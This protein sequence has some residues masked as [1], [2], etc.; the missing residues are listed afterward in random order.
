[1]K[2]P[3][4]A[5]ALL[6]AVLA[7]GRLHAQQMN[8]ARVVPRGWIE[9]R[10]FGDFA[11]YDARFADGGTV[12]LGAPYVPAY[13]SLA[14]R[15]A[16]PVLPSL[17]T[18]VA[19]FFQQTAG[20][21]TNPTAPTDLAIGDVNF[22][23][24]TDLR[25]V[26][27]GVDFGLTSRISLGVT[28]PF[29]RRSSSPTELL[30]RG[31]TVGINA[32]PERNAVLLG[33]IDP[34]YAALGRLAF[35]PTAESAAGAEL[36][37]RVKAIV[38]DSV[39][40]VL[41]TRGV[42]LQELLND[43]GR[44]ALLDADEQAALE[45]RNASAGF[46]L[47]DV[48]VGARVMLFNTAPATPFAD[49]ARA[50]GFRSTLGVRARLA[51]GASADTAYLLEV[52]SRNGHF[53][54]G[55][56]LHNDWFLSRRWWVTAAGTFEQRFGADVTRRAFAAD[57]PFPPDTALRT[58]HR[59]PGAR[60][61]ASV[62]PRYRLTREWGFAGFYGFEY[63]AET[64]F[65]AADD[66]G[67]VVLNPFEELGGWTAHRVGFGASY[68]TYEAYRQGR[69]P[70]PIEF[71]LLYRNTVAGDNLAPEAASIEVGGRFIYQL[72]GRPRRARPDTAAVDTTPPTPPEGPARVEPRPTDE[73]QLRPP[74]P[75]N[76]APAPPAPRPPPPPPPPPPTLPPGRER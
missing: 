43:P 69:T 49:S 5:A 17:Q 39:S 15:L 37:R 51:T 54:V 59:T 18:S 50:T 9:V 72:F 52:P 62:T 45:V 26:P 27:L 41:P 44:R 63:E 29:E 12:A 65:S 6:L 66:R 33:R 11:R 61:L 38:G 16:A 74:S 40:L 67:P 20:Q 48:E 46:R 64:E 4:G 70:V 30:L 21:V 68:S 76:P 10:G 25:R 36:Q 34:A 22:E 55:V 53:G 56:D 23:V 42:S 3:R 73:P 2:L 71:W 8:D 24:S 13:Q 60:F 1:M 14:A 28:V 32:N 35:L 47:G 19:A 75:E 57:R 58:L 31:G 7:T